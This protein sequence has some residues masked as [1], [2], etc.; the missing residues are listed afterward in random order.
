M[1]SKPVMKDIRNDG[2]EDKQTVR[3]A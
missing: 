2:T 1:S 3:Y